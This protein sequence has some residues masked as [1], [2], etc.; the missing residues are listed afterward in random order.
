MRKTGSVA[1]KFVA[2]DLEEERA[3]RDFDAD[4]MQK[5]LYNGEEAINYNKESFEFFNKD[6]IRNDL[7]FYEM[8]PYEQ[9]ELTWGKLKW[10]YENHGDKF[11]KSYEMLKYPY[12]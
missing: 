7:K 12:H 1:N 4:E 2:P 6:G 5:F 8:T 11:F 10:I 3:K 9:Q